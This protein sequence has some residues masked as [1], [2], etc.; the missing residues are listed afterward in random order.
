ML[1]VD[2]NQII[3]IFVLLRISRPHSIE[4]MADTTPT[5]SSLAEMFFFC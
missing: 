2:L 5:R 4:W 1:W 3:A